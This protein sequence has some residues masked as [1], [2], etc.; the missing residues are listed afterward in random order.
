MKKTVIIFWSLLFFTNS[1]A[2]NKTVTTS[3]NILE[4]TL[5][6][7]ALVST[8]IWNDDHTKPTWQFVKA[9]ASA[10]ILE[11]AL[12]H[13]VQK[14]RPDGSD[15]YSFPSGHTTSAFSGASFIQ[16]RYGWKYGIPSYILASYVGYTRIQA[17]KHDGW[18]VLAGATIG[19]GTSYLFT[20]PYQK[21][22]V[23]VTL[24]KISGGYLV[25]FNYTF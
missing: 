17:K 8:F 13:I 6:V 21:T 7:A 14:P 3:G 24:N 9:Y 20:K 18:D 19:I 23:D 22:K 16:R 15:N 10:T 5:P 2:Q 11:Q 1:N 4:V 12:K 25:G